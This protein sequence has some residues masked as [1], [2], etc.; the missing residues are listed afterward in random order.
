M[1]Y[2]SLWE[3][4]SQERLISLDLLEKDLAACVADGDLIFNHYG[5][6]PPFS[7][8][9]YRESRLLVLEFLREQSL[10]KPRSVVN[11]TGGYG[12]GV[13]GGDVSVLLKS[14]TEGLLSCPC[15]NDEYA[16]LDRFHLTE[17]VK[18]LIAQHTQTEPS[19]WDITFTSTGTEAMDFAYQL[20]QLEGFN[21][22]TGINKRQQKDVIIA[23]RGAWHGW[24]LASNQF[25]DRRQF[26]EGLPRFSESKVVF[27][28]YG[29]IAQ[30]QEL[31]HTYQGRIK[32]IFVEG[33]L[34]DG[35]IVVGSLDWW[36]RLL[37]LAK[38]EDA[39][40]VDDEIL[41]CMRTGK[42]LALPEGRAPDCITLGKGLGFGV[43]PLSLV[44][45]KKGNL[46]P[47]PGIGVR[48][49]NARPLHSR[50]VLQG[51]KYID[52]EGLFDRSEV[53]GSTLIQ[54]LSLICDAYPS[55]YKAVRGQ[56]LLI[57]VELA[58]AFGRKGRYVRDELIRAGVLT[59]LESGL[60]SP[61]LPKNLR[62]NQTIRLTP[63]LTTPIE[64]VEAIVK[65]FKI[66]GE[67]LAATSK[68]ALRDQ[69][70]QPLSVSS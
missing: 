57:G 62:I 27:H 26:T 12:T 48:T 15:A 68:G 37:S 49:F 13:L 54:A 70:V 20:V 38:T 34:G 58:D 52:E 10:V 17:K 33:I 63:P 59:E 32:A 41:T 24:G 35:G 44:A 64:E 67:K 29:D 51:L 69:S 66:V 61:Q 2:S 16:N 7:I 11:A 5:D 56:G 14:L 43:F 31:F 55:V 9:E 39:R 45:W 25:L 47:R 22:L 65:S 36:D 1:D 42:F 8:L 3:C 40:V 46:S 4:A 6:K 53:L 23:C 21:L 19:D 18:I 28:Q 30:L 60:T 50:V